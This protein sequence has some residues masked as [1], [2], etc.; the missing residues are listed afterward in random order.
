MSEYWRDGLP[1]E[2]SIYFVEIGYQ[3]LITM[4]IFTIYR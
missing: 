3:E 4:K 1:V 2:L